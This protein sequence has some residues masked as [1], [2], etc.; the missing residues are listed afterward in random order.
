[1]SHQPFSQVKH[2]VMQL[3]SQGALPEAIA[4]LEECVRLVPKD[5]EAVWVLSQ[6][7]E[8]AGRL[9]DAFKSYLMLSAQVSPVRHQAMA[10]AL[11]IAY[12]RDDFSQGLG[13]AEQLLKLEPN[14]HEYWYKQGKMLNGLSRFLAASHSFAQALKYAPDKEHAKTYRLDYARDL[15]LLGQNE[16][17]LMILSGVLHEA[18]DTLGEEQDDSLAH[19]LYVACLNYAESQDNGKV[20]KAHRD[21]GAL[22][23]AKFSENTT[24]PR[25]SAGSRLKVAFISNDFRNHSV[26]LF[27]KPIL[28]HCSRDQLEITCYSDVA[29][30]D[31]TTRELIAL[32]EHWCDISGMSDDAVYQHIRADQQDILVDLVGYLG[33]VRLGVFARRAAPIQINY[34]GYANTTG[35]QRMDYRIS[36]EVTDPQPQSAQWHSETLLPLPGL[37]LCFEPMKAAPDVAPLPATSNGYVT[38]GSTNVYTK[39]TQEMLDIWVELLKRC[40]NARLIVK[41]KQFSEAAFKAKIL[42]ELETKLGEQGRIE[43]LGWLPRGESHLGFYD[44]IDIHLDTFPYN[45]TTT[46]FEA[47]W[48]G[49][50]SV[51]L[52]GDNHRSRVGM[53]IMHNIG[54]GDWVAHSRQEYIQLALDKAENLLELENFRHGIRRDM[55]QSGVLDGSA[56][57]HKLTDCLQ[58]AWEKYL[59]ENDVQ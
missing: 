34:L 44:R 14:H 25:K 42:N 12:L 22:L 20:F 37:F 5:L 58:Q 4:T 9:E 10:R 17:A 57:V 3:V 38:F 39:V 8:K 19:Y 27:F 26:A 45:G 48:Q 35:L 13:L 31:D 53:S 49:V 6:L 11:H 47:L 59:S 33:T 56:F 51:T 32:A 50:P 54:H 7:R 24:F 36:D 23:E 30:S 16:Q 18:R 52:A 55:Q 28:E 43:V 29:R 41:A 40:P 1:M 21:F 15:S 46:T 2:K